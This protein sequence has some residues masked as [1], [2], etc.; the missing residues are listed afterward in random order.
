MD[1][2][3]TDPELHLWLRWA[4]ESGRTPMFVREVVEAALIASLPHYE[5]LRPLMVEHKRR[6]PGG[7]PA[8][9]IPAI[10]HG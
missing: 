10:L 4:S 7:S 9:E 2:P 1:S 5:L 6:Y 3:H 8:Q